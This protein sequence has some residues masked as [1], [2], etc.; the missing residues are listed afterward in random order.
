MNKQKIAEKL[1]RLSNVVKA[2][3]LRNKRNV[4]FHLKNNSLNVN[5]NVDIKDDMNIDFDLKEWDEMLNQSEN[6]REY[7]K[8]VAESHARTQNKINILLNDCINE[9]NNELNQHIS[10]CEDIFEKLK[11]DDSKS[12]QE[13]KRAYANT[14]RIIK[15]LQR[16]FPDISGMRVLSDWSGN[17]NDVNSI[18]LG[19]AAEGGEI[20]G[21]PAADY[22]ISNPKWNF[23]VNPKL[24]RALKKL[25]YYSEW[26]D[27]GTLMAYPL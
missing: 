22:Y 9:I 17:P 12:G 27:A 21:L 20:D 11:N 1:I 26:Y 23:G 18:H 5:I 16:K 6:E 15:K 10:V 14:E 2:S 7:E 19:D 24:D 13:F 8:S 3:T 4:H 25:G